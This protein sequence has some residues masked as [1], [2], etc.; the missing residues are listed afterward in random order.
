MFVLSSNRVKP[1]E[2]SLVYSL[3]TLTGNVEVLV[4]DTVVKLPDI[5]VHST[6]TFKQIMMKSLKYLDKV[7][8]FKIILCQ[9]CYLDY[10]ENF[11]ML[12]FS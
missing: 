7:I 5:G 4:D 3:Y 11:Q 6:L 1:G 12:R 8:C 2:V 10:I 9:S